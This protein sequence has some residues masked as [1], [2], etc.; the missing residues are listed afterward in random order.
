MSAGVRVR[1]YPTPRILARLKISRDDPAEEMTDTFYDH[2][3]DGRPLHGAQGCFL[4]VRHSAAGVRMTRRCSGVGGLRQSSETEVAELDPDATDVLCRYTFQRRTSNAFAPAGIEARLDTVVW[5]FPYEVVTLLKVSGEPT[6]DVAAEL[7]LAVRASPRGVRPLGT[8]TKFMDMLRLGPH[9]S[10]YWEHFLRLD[11]F[12]ADPEALRHAKAH[13]PAL[14]KTYLFYAKARAQVA[15]MN[16]DGGPVETF[17]LRLLME[18][19]LADRL[20][21][22]Q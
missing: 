2:V 16:R 22:K 6:E 4:R 18:S 3:A 11:Y 19:A 8:R 14:F 1:M 21:S 17:E 10:L 7:L 9:A 20:L 12:A 13:D 5:P 15:D